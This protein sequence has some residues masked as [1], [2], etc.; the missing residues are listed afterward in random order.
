MLTSELMLIKIFNL[1][2]ESL[3]KKILCASVLAQ[4]PI[5]QEFVDLQTF[6]VNTVLRFEN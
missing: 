4:E 5:S 1:T 3:P 6:L 2:A